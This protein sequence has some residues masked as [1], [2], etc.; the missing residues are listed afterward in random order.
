MLYNI[1]MTIFIGADHR[2]FNLKNKLIEYLQEKNIRVEDMGNYVHDPLDDNP[3]Y[4]QKVAQAVLQH[5]E[6][7]MG[8]I[9]CGSGIGVAIAANRYKGI[10]CALGFDAQQI[11]HGRENDHINVLALPAEYI[12]LETAKKY[13]DT[14]MSAQPKMQEKYLR[15]VEKVD[16]LG[17]NSSNSV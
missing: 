16:S 12:D 1:S 5:P 8:I 10:R 15:R 2:G 4:A 17:N 13:V 7:H 11:Q 9:I 14:F 6:H 3:D